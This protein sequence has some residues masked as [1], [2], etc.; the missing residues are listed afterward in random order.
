MMRDQARHLEAV[1]RPLADTCGAI[2]RLLSEVLVLER[3]PAL[4][5][6]LAVAGGI[7]PDRS[8]VFARRSPQVWLAWGASSEVKVHRTPP[9]GHAI[10]D[11]DSIT[12]TPEVASAYH[13]S[14]ES[15]RS[16]EAAATM[17]AP[18]FGCDGLMARSEFERLLAW[19][20]LLEHSCYMAAAD[21]SI[22]AEELRE[23]LVSRFFRS[24]P[25]PAFELD[26][27]W[28]CV[29]SLAHLVLLALREGR[30]WLPNMMREL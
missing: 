30:L 14:I 4:R 17:L 12:R 9:P 26:S 22:V 20:P 23:G 28:R 18:A 6:M 13:G 11:L 24:E 7:D 16:V 5:R 19:S 8:V 15:T 21:L 25:L 1:M 27:Y 2:S 10:L 29:H 3:D